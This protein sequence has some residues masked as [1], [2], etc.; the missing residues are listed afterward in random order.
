VSADFVASDYCYN[1]LKQAM[2]RHEEQKALVIPVILRPVDW[3]N[4]PF[5]KLQTLPRSGKPIASWSSRHRREKAFLEVALGIRDAIKSIKSIKFDRKIRGTT[6]YD[7][8]HFLDRKFAEL[9]RSRASV[10]SDR[11]R[12]EEALTI[13]EQ[14][15]CLDPDDATAYSGKGDALKELHHYE[16][17]TDAYLQALRLDPDDAAVYRSMGDILTELHHYDTALTAYEHALRLDPNDFVAFQR[18]A[19]VEHILFWNQSSQK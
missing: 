6:D 9:Q 18:K 2:T 8:S 4:A 5:G 11:G 17:A 15:L 1:E 3:K 13:Y 10:Y 19:M 12:Y 16:E 14:A 7:A